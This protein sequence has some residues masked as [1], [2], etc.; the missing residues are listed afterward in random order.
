MGGLGSDAAIEASDIVIMD[1]DLLKVAEARHLAKKTMKTATAV[2]ITSIALKVLFMIL[3]VTGLL[4]EFAMIV[5]GLSD[6][7]VMI[8]C[9]LLALTM[10]FYKPK[11]LKH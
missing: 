8:I 6:T 7:G 1:D 11:Y 4:G 2:I 3:V 10:T 9:V 5:S